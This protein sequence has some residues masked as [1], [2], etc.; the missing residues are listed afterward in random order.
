VE[1]SQGEEVVSL[2]IDL[3]DLATRDGEQATFA[4]HFVALCKSQR[5][6]RGFFAWWKRAEGRP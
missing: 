5:R 2:A 6:R 1:T 4:N 3:R